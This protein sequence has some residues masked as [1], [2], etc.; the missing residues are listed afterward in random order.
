MGAG[1]PNRVGDRSGRNLDDGWGRFR[2]LR[3]R[4]GW[5]LGAKNPVVGLFDLN[6]HR[7]PLIIVEQVIRGE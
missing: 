3:Y 1:I 6:D 4:C 7:F 2:G 5:R